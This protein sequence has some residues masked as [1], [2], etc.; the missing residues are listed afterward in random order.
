MDSNTPSEIQN[1]PT[2]ML[3]IRAIYQGPGPLNG[4]KLLNVPHRVK[5]GL[6]CVLFYSIFDFHLSILCLFV[7]RWDGIVCVCVCVW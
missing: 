7:V 6:N 3:L 4:A 2:R 5:F 1:T